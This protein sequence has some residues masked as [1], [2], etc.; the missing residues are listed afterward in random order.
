MLQRTYRLINKDYTCPARC[1]TKYYK[2][3][4]I[5]NDAKCDCVNFCKFPPLENL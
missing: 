1:Y 4:E 2:N 5:K 3:T